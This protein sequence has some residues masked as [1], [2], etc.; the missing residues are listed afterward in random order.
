[1]KCEICSGKIG[2]TFLSKILGTVIKD[3]SGKKHTICFE[4]QKK[5]PDKN[6][7]L[8]NLK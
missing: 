1:M 8:K 6:T 5:F 7:A 2:E 4:C 3:E